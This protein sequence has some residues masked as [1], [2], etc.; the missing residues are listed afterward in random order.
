MDVYS[1]SCLDSPRLFNVNLGLR[2][3]RI[4]C[5]WEIELWPAVSSEPGNNKK[6]AGPERSFN[7]ILGLEPSI[8]SGT[9]T[10]ILQGFESE[11]FQYLPCCLFWCWKLPFDA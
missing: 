8:C 11:T 3:R 10:Y 9:S 1:I 5:R 2:P 7:N 4:T 6:N